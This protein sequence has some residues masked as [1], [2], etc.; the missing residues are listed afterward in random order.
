MEETTTKEINEKKDFLLKFSILIAILTG[1]FTGLAYN[2]FAFLLPTIVEAEPSWNINEM[3]LGNLMGSMV[4]VFAGAGLIAAYYVDSIAKKPVAIFGGIFT[5]VSCVLA[6]LAPTW[7]LFCVAIVLIGIGNGII[8]P[9]VFA[10]ISDITP[11]EKRSTNY[12]LVLFLGVIGGL[13][14]AV[15]FFGFILTMGA[16][17]QPYI[18]TGGLIIGFSVAMFVIKLPK[19]GGKEHALKEI[20]E[21][22]DVE[23]EYKLQ[24]GDL[25]D[26]FKRKS[27]IVLILNFADALPT[28][29]FMFA[30]LWLTVEHGLDLGVALTLAILLLIFRFASPPIWGKIA[31][32]IHKKTQDD[33]S[34]I[35]ICLILLMV[36]TPIF[37]VAIL[38]PWD[39][40]GKNMSEVLMMPEFVAFLILLCLAFFISSGTQPI[41]QSAISEINLPEHRATSY[42]IAMFVDQV[43]V[44]IGVFAAGALIVLFA[45]NGYT[46]A[47]IFAAIAG[48]INLITWF[49]ALKY[50][51]ED[52]KY[53]QN[54]LLE[55]AEELKLKA[56]IKTE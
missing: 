37:I 40:T 1:I 10:L 53:I 46:V 38:I 15:I 24:F 41:W 29:I 45:P 42:Q 35:K 22:S 50:Y 33:A 3:M 5:G 51:P 19:R 56:G 32:N 20:L 52:K 47:F 2:V 27:N 8:S 44:A 30:T 7:E 26:I 43:G 9:V 12:G 25:K 14:G 34:K 11:P 17:R 21:V 49:L 13:A 48:G 16:W 6:G 55:R 23:Y 54:L 18:L 31:D 4:L 36:Y 39:A 28:G